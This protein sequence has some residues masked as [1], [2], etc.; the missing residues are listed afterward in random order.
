M[1]PT[2]KKRFRER[3]VKESPRSNDVGGSSIKYLTLLLLFATVVNFGSLSGTDYN[4]VLTALTK[5]K[6]QLEDASECGHKQERLHEI[7]IKGRNPAPAHFYCLCPKRSENCNLDFCDTIL[8]F[9]DP[10][11]PASE[12]SPNSFKYNHFDLPGSTW[13][14]ARNAMFYMAQ[15]RRRKAQFEGR[16][17]ESHYCFM[18]GDT[19]VNTP[20][21]LVAEQLANETETNKIIVFNYRRALNGV[22]YLYGA[23]ANLNCFSESSMDSYLPYSNI[24]DSQAWYLS[25]FDLQ[26]RANIVEPF[27]FK[28]YQ[29]IVTRN[30]SHNDYPRDGLD[31]IQQLVDWQSAEGFSEGCAPY[32]KVDHGNHNLATH[33]VHCTF[34]DTFIFTMAFNRTHRL[35][36]Y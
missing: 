4:A 33:V 15:R 35:K 31:G 17:P 20:K 19:R 7:S 29:N 13:T 21:H 22:Q 10:A 25:Q 2:D 34:G 18:D 14:T 27:V 23:D 3:R 12:E 28:L 6:Q 24:L 9:D 16:S 1:S 5:P 36:M 11:G 8:T 30:P 32:T 26:M